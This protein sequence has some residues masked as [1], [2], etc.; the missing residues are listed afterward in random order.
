MTSIQLVEVGFGGAQY[1]MLR[2]RGDETLSFAVWFQLDHDGLW[3]LRR[4]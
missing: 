3:R 2:Q 4:F 1:E